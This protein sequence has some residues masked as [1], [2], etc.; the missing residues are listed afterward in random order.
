MGHGNRKMKKTLFR[1]HT[2]WDLML[3]RLALNFSGSASLLLEERLLL[4]SPF[5]KNL[6]A[7]ET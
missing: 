1:L 6:T 3:T 5:L 2:L 7:A 4:G